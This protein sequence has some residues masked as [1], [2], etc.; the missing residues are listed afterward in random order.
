MKESRF[1]SVL[2]ALIDVIWAGF[3][4]LVCSLPLVTLGASSTAL[5]YVTVKC[6]RHERVALRPLFFAAPEHALAWSHLAHSYLLGGD[7]LV[8]PVVEPAADS[9]WVFL[10]AGDWLHLWSGRRY[11]PGEH[12]V[13]APLGEPPVFYRASSEFAELFAS[14]REN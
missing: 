13:P 14:L 8:A 3:L 7:L 12:E 6:I 4:W 10:P 2:S 1:V 11:A 9:R 5:Y